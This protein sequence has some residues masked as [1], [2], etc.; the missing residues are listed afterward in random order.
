MGSLHLQNHGR[1][2]LNRLTTALEDRPLLAANSV[3]Q[4]R[5]RYKGAHAESPRALAPAAKMAA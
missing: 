2:D 5:Q 1:N 4:P 3:R